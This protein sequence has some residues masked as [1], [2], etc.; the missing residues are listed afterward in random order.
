[1]ARWETVG[2]TVGAD[3]FTVSFYRDGEPV[4]ET[5]PVK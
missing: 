2:F 4:R 5:L 3:G 1:M